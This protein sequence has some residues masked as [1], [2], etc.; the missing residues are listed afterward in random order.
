MICSNMSRPSEPPSPPKADLQDRARALLEKQ[1]AVLDRMAD[2]GL[3]IV[4]ALRDEALAPEAA[5]AAPLAQDIGLAYSRVTRAVRLTLALQTQ[6]MEALVAL[7][8]P[9]APAPSPA[10]GAGAPA[11]NPAASRRNRV[12]AVVER[13]ILAEKGGGREFERLAKIAERLLEDEDLCDDILAKPMSEL[14]DMICHDLG[15]S[16]EWLRLAEEAWA[17]REVETG[18]VGAPLKDPEAFDAAV[19]AAKTP[20]PM[21]FKWL[22]SDSEAEPEY[23]SP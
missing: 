16:P 23:A 17:Q 19:R 1:L 22:D 12:R 2:A 6:V 5:R 9:S 21:V 15:L 18:P 11:P 13:V 8:Q 14:V 3:D 4:L 7:D 20:P 10:S